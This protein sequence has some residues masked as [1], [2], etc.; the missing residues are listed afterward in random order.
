MVILGFHFLFFFFFFSYSFAYT[1]TDERTREEITYVIFLFSNCSSTMWRLMMN[2]QQK[3]RT[4]L[5]N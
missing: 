4:S 2:N 1:Y 3:K 5:N